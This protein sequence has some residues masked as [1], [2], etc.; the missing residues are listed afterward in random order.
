M[1]RDFVAQRRIE[2]IELAHD[3]WLNATNDERAAKAEA[4][5]RELPNGFTFLGV[6]D[7]GLGEQRFPVAIFSWRESSFSLVPGGQF[8]IG[9]NADGWRPNEDEIE[10]YGSSAAEYDITET[11]AE[12]VARATLR[13]RT[14]EVV[15]LLVETIAEEVGWTS[16]GRDDADVRYA[17]ERLPSGPGPYTSSVSRG[18][19]EVRV[20]RSAD[21]R[22]KAERS[23]DEA[24]H[25]VLSKQL[26]LDGFR[27]PTSDEWEFLC[28]AG[29]RTLF[30][31]GDHVPC[32][33]YPPDISPE[34]AAWRRE[35]VLSRGQLERPREGFNSDWDFHRQP[36]AFGLHI[37]SDPYMYELV[38]EADRTRGGDGGSMICGGT[39]FFLG[40]LTLATAYFED[41]ACLRDPAEPISTGYTVGRRVM[42]LR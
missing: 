39:G 9:W 21:G 20:Q 17:L 41:H 19:S 37:A 15:P 4:L 27:F 30:R 3:A 23:I 42:P 12:Y 16:I 5:L 29:A 32:D 18:D 34:E 35:W 13:P 38:A 10:S 11:L 22:I 40:W 14:I 26:A 24:T 8:E 6:R 36:N 7:H 31:W 25:A 28:G 33:R 1:G 2:M